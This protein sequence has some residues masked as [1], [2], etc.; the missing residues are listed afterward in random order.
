[1]TGQRGTTGASG[2]TGFSGFDGRTGASG[3]RGPTGSTGV[4][5]FSGAPGQFG[6]NGPWGATGRTGATGSVGALGFTGDTGSTGWSKT[7][8]IYI[9]NIKI[10]N[11]PSSL[12]TSGTC[13]KILEIMRQDLLIM[14]FLRMDICTIILRIRWHESYI[15]ISYKH[16]RNILY[17]YTN[18]IS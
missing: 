1:V 9:I 11:P 15:A 5:G 12:R 2:D 10:I 3:S 17:R 8:R 13:S 4:R 7:I 14:H 16:V 6:N 18:K